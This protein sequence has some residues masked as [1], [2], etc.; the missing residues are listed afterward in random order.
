VTVIPATL[1]EGELTRRL[2]AAEIA[3]VIKLGRHA[4][5]VCRVLAGLGLLDHAIYVE[6]ATQAR[7]RVAPLAE[8][9][10]ASVPYFA[11]ALVRGQR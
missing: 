11:M 5:K 3:A 7:Q 9:D 8:I 4:G 10:P 6:R 2:V 1:A